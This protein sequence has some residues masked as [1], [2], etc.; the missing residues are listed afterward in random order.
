MLTHLLDPKT[1]EVVR[2]VPGTMIH[3]N[4][5]DRTCFITVPTEAGPYRVKFNGDDDKLM[6]PIEGAERALS[7]LMII[8]LISAFSGLK[9]V[10]RADLIHSNTLHYVI[11]E[12][13][14]P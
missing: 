13:V 10:L 12:V 6:F 1:R 2:V 3:F 8:G 5:R 14:A 11:Y 4:T 7:C 9:F